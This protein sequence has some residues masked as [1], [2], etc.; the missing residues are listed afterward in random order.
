[1]N[2]SEF[3]QFA[4]EYDQLHAKNIA[5]TGEKPEFF[6]EYKL[7]LLQHFVRQCRVE[8]H[9]ILDFGSGV[10]NSTRFLRRYFPDARLASADVSTRS[11]DVA[12]SRFPNV[13]RR[14]HVQGK[15]IPADDNSFDVIFCACVFHH[16][17]HD[18][19]VHWLCELHRVARPG[20]LLSIFEHNPLNPLTVRAVNTCPFDENAHLIAAT[21]FAQ[22]YRQ[23]GWHNPAVRF[24]LFFPR[25]LGFLRVLEPHLS[26]IP[27]GGQYSVTAVK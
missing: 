19:H 12:Q 17:P 4:D 26:A 27:F 25:A 16:I 10:G 21:D 7:R 23:S 24:H 20:A 18:E 1:M 14:L 11:L 5:V 22:R 9:D 6:H 3:D 8:A 13:S 15:R 2:T